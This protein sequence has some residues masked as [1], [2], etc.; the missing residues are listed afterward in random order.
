MNVQQMI[1]R[2]GNLK[3][4][5]EL[6][7]QEERMLKAGLIANG[8]GSYEGEKYIAE[9]QHYE[10]ASI[11]PTLVRKYSNEDFIAQVTEHKMVDAVVV[12]ARVL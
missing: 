7:E 2:L 6:I 1:D 4:K 8:I 11:S 3:A 5:R 12:K 9:V 10:R